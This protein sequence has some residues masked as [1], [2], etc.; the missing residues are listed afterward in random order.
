MWIVIIQLTSRVEV[1]DFLDIKR[2]FI[3]LLNTK[4][5]ILEHTSRLAWIPVWNTNHRLIFRVIEYGVFLEI[6]PSQI[7][8]QTFN[9]K[10]DMKIW[11]P[12]LT[13]E[14]MPYYVRYCAW[15]CLS[16]IF[17]AELFLQQAIPI[18]L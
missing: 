1:F 5:I 3:L 9:P 4:P 8:F 10:C 14:Y 12:Y 2:G 6:S 16:Y 13:L 17:M 11:M 15:L 7:E 18:Y